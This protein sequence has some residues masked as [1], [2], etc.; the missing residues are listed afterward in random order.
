MLYRS[1]TT[2]SRTE[3]APTQAQYRTGDAV[4][5]RRKGDSRMTKPTVHPKTRSRM[6][7]S[8]TTTRPGMEK[9]WTRAPAPGSCLRQAHRDHSRS[10]NW[11]T[12]EYR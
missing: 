1:I 11:I 8:I 7:S 2:M 9:P 12:M 10:P 4:R 6:S 3:T 5:N